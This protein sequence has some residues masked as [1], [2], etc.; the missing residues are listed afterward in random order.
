MNITSRTILSLCT[1]TTFL[2][3]SSARA[4][5]VFGERVN[6]KSV[7]PVID[8]EYDMIDCLSYDGL[9][10]Y[11]DSE[12]AGGSGGWDLWVS[13]RASIDEDW[14]PPENLE[15]IVNS[16]KTDSAAS[17]SADG[18]TLYFYSDRPGGYGNFDIYM[19]T[20]ATRQDPW[21]Q[22]VNLGP[23]INK[24]VVGDATPW[25]SADDLE[26]Y[27]ESYRPGG[28]G[29]ADIY[30]S[31][32]A[33]LHDPWGEPVNLGS[34]VNT[35]YHEAYPSLSPDGLVLFF[36]DGAF[37]RP[38]GYGSADMWM[39]RRASLSDPWQTPVN[40]G[41]VV[42]GPDVD[43]PP[44]ISPDGRRIYFFSG[45]NEDPTTW[46]NYQ[47]SIIPIVDFN[48]DGVVDLADLV[49]LIDNWGTNST[50]CDIGP[51][52]WGDGKVDIEDLKVF[53]GYWEQENAVKS[54]DSP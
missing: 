12:R 38:G 39:T 16:M 35:P 23:K 7:I 5:F 45:V 27:L 20:R 50:L 42:N 18:L 14:G 25:I 4:D 8:P 15:P 1:V 11:F 31:R 13:R 52:A 33:T 44:R 10:M 37:P 36:T 9:E 46:N 51:Y 48:A 22:P 49:V 21:G 2:G 53:L 41:P 17:I 29:Q 32:R 6:L 43:N 28:Y 47:A 24:P 3:A 30:V 26:L 54:E 19:T 34:V 40:L